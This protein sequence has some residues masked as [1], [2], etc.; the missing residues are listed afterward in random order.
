MTN[1]AIHWSEGLFISPH[2]FQSGERRLHEQLGL[3]QQWHVG[4]AYGL[5][6]IELD[7]AALANWRVGVQTLHVQFRDGTLLRFPEDAL[8]SPVEIPQSAFRSPQDRLM[9]HVAVPQMQLGR[10][11]ANSERGDNT[12]RYIVE[13]QEVEDE[14]QGGN[15][16]ITQVRWLNARLLVGNDDVAGYETLPIMRLRLGSVAEAPPELDPEYIPPLLACDAWDYLQKSILQNTTDYLGSLADQLARNMLDRGVAFQSGNREDLERIQ[17]LQAVNTALGHLVNLGTVRGMHPLNA[18]IDLSRALGS[19][20][21]FRPDRQLRMPT[22]PVYDHDNLGTCFHTVRKLIDLGERPI[23]IKRPFIGAG[24]Q[25]QVRLD[26]EWLTPGWTFYM[27]VETTL[28]FSDIE[29]LLLKKMDLKI[30]SPDTVEKIYRGGR[31]DVKTR[32][33]ASPPRD[34]PGT[35]WTYWKLDRS[36]EAWQAVEAELMLAIRFNENQ[37]ASK[38]DAE[39]TIQ[40]RTDQ[41]QLV[42]LSF[43]LFAMPQTSK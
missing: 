38:Y 42:A 12:C 13:S 14:N 22:I 8:L 16:I 30:G 41:G 5:R 3:A 4:Y 24:L 43:A 33:E 31:G 15:P 26:K 11:N 35:N 23:Y 6:K 20:S 29:T 17:K 10:K 36:S 32:P 21:M 28:S 39:Q 18:Y 40:V 9:I 27:G 2:H 1:H 7:T 34:F 25:M 37:V 19:V